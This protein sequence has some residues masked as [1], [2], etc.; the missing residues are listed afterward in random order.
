M[1]GLV[2]LFPPHFSTA[3]VTFVAAIAQE[4]VLV[5]RPVGVVVRPFTLFQLDRIC[6]ATG[7]VFVAFSVLRKLLLVGVAGAVLLLR[8]GIAGI[9]FGFV[10]LAFVPAMVRVRALGSLGT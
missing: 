10:G 9:V 2:H 3:F 4:H 5:A 7:S 1:R 8:V 6:S